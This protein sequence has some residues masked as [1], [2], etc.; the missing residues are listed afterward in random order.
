MRCFA[1][2]SKLS[3]AATVVALFATT[4]LYASGSESW[5]SAFAVVL[6]TFALRV[7]VM[8]WAATLHALPWSR[9][10]GTFGEGAAR[11]RVLVSIDDPGSFKEAVTRAMAWAARASCGSEDQARALRTG[12]ARSS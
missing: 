5:R 3:S 6:A 7:L 8:A 12:P 9:P 4:A 11:T 2:I 1:A 10:I